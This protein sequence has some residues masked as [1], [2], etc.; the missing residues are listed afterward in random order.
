[1]ARE[2]IPRFE[3]TESEI[4]DR[5]IE[6]LDDT[7]RKEPGDYMYDAVAAN[8]LEI[9]QLQVNQDEILKAGFAQ[10]AEDEDLD[11]HMYHVGLR[12]LEAT[13]NR[14]RLKVD[15]DAGVIVP[16]GHLAS[17]VVLDGGG[18]PIEYTV[19]EGVT[20]AET[21]E[22]FIDI[23]STTTG[24]IANV[25]NGSSFI[26]LPPIPGVR[27][28]HDAGTTVTARDRESD[29]S[30][31]A[32]YDFKLRYP[33]TG[34]NKHDYVRWASEVPGVGKVR[35]VPRWQNQLFVKLVVVDDNYEPA[36]PETVEDLQ[37]YL[38]PNSE[39]L[40]EGKAP[41]GARV[42]V[43]A[44]HGVPINIA[45]NVIYAEGADPAAVKAQFMEASREYLRSLVFV[46]DIVGYNK[47]GALLGMIPEVINY[48]D[49][50]INGDTVD[51]VLGEDDSPVLG[52]VDI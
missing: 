31:L 38:D 47:I 6:R 9:L 33:D 39:G 49:L 1:M 18:D 2:Y 42:F 35:V 17:V 41:G 7:W 15:A 45:A 46:S 21:G 43:F 25:T 22:R 52:T 50:T 20:F 34:G 16:A 29:E 3:E 12:R 51:V 37:T 10:T 40:G 48:S 5:Q 28:I 44:S 19:D 8:P 24:A 11:E 32:R 23:T 4:L 14:R 26:F 27:Q 36:P 30:A 13:A